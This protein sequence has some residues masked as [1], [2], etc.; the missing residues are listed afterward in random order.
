MSRRTRSTTSSSAENADFKT[1]IDS[2]KA[3]RNEGYLWYQVA[4]FTYD[5]FMIR[6]R[7][8]G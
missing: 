7:T 6:N 1:I 2:V 8:K 5:S 4:E 3:F